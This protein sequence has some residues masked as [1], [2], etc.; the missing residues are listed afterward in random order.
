M[1]EEINTLR[2]ETRLQKA[3]LK[4]STD[5]NDIEEYKR[6]DKLHRD[7]SHAEGNLLSDAYAAIYPNAR[8]ITPSWGDGSVNMNLDKV[9]QYEVD[10][11]IRWVAIEAKGGGSGLGKRLTADKQHYAQQG[12]QEYWNSLYKDMVDKRNRMEQNGI[13]VP[14]EMDSIIDAMKDNNF[15][16]IAV[17]KA[18]YDQGGRFAG[19]TK[20]VFPP[21]TPPAS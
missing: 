8:V 17:S 19:F 18:I 1:A 14:P 11:E 3:A 7:L 21:K 10:G 15:E 13:A 6:L 16:Y 12:S 2:D 9:I 20:S 4:D 5:P